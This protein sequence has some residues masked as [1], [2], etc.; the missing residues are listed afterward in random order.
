MARLAGDNLVL[1]FRQADSFSR[2][3][4]RS[5]M[6]THHDASSWIACLR[7]S[8]AGR[9]WAPESY[10][11]AY[12]SEFGVNDPALTRLA[13][14]GLLL[15]VTEIDVRPSA[16]RAALGPR[17]ISHRVE[18]GR[19][20][21]A[22]GNVVVPLALESGETVTA[23]RLVEAGDLTASFSREPVMELA[24]GTWVL[25]VYAG[26]PFVTD[27]AYLIRSYDRGGRWGDASTIFRD[28]S[29]GP[30]DLQGINFNETAVL[31]FPDG[32]MLAMGRA[33]ETFHT[34]GA[35]IPVGGVGELRSA[36]SFNSGL[37]WSRPER[38]EIFGQ[39]AHLLHLG[40]DRVLCTYGYRRQPYGI[41]AVESRDRGRT[42]LVDDTVVLRDDAPGWDMGYPMT[43][44][45]DEKLFLTTYYFA[46]DQGVRFIAS[47][48]WSI[49]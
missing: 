28:E 29:G 40:G 49:D 26:A 46:D 37:S 21:A 35:F 16:E 3:A 47:T 15:R 18:H 48:T 8:D 44:Q 20:A 13:D 41:R 32:E 19:V 45:V 6:V 4:A 33:D 24:D 22:R 12:R 27:A 10:R 39:P 38:T 14:G 17:L 42:W 11:V 2:D 34:E 23:G 7:S 36:R 1:V 9:S 31:A 25:P 43:L 5:G 30:S